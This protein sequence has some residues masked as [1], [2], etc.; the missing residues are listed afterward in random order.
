MI[1]IH[2]HLQVISPRLIFNKELFNVFKYTKKITLNLWD[3]HYEDEDDEYKERLYSISLWSLLSVIRETSLEEII[4]ELGEQ[5]YY[6]KLLSIYPISF[7]LKRAYNDANYNISDLVPNTGSS[8]DY[9]WC[10]ISLK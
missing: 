1:A 9:V 5:K 10:M 2:H 4:L 3:Y 8:G 6:N 7:E